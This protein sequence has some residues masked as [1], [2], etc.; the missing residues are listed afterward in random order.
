MARFKNF[1]PR[2]VI[3]ATL[4]AFNDDYSINEKETRRHLRHV[5]DVRGLAAITVNGHASEVH[6]CTF[7]EQ[8]RILAVSAQEV[9]VEFAGLE[10][11]GMRAAAERI[12][13]GKTIRQ[14]GRC[15]S[16]SLQGL[17]Q[18]RCLIGE[19]VGHV[20]GP[21]AFGQPQRFAKDSN[22]QISGNERFD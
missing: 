6:A 8:Q 14:G 20:D 15:Q 21:V 3:P 1:V 12:G 9:T 22:R 5:A 19:R 2:G 13:E 10:P 16:S 7:D 18:S 17:H 11:G 4:L